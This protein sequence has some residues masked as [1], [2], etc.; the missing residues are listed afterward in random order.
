MDWLEVRLVAT[1]THLRRTLASRRPLSAK[2]NDDSNLLR[3]SARASLLRRFQEAQLPQTLFAH[4][5]SNEFFP[6]RGDLPSRSHLAS[7]Q[8]HG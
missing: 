3:K 1:P 7:N 5:V 6:S 8:C 4:T 2:N